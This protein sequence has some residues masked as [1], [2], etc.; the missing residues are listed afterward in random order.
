MN[1]KNYNVMSITRI[2]GAFMAYLIGSG[3]ATGQE[4]LQ[5]F[6]SFGFNGLLGCLISLTILIYACNTLLNVGYKHN[7]RKNE[8]VF[9]YFCGKYIGKFLT[10]YTMTFIVAVYAIMLSGTGATLQQYYGVPG[11]VGAILMAV[12]SGG[13]L[14][15]GLR[16]IVNIIAMIGPVIVLFTVVIS[17]LT[18]VENPTAIVNGAEKSVELDMLKA[19]PNWV[20]SA[21][22]YAGL[23]IPGLASFL[24][25]IGANSKRSKDI[26]YSSLFGPILFIGSLFLLALALMTQIELVNGTQIPVM[27]LANSVLPIYASIFAIIIFFGIFTTATPLLWTVCSRFAEDKTPKYNALVVGLVLLGLLGGTLLPFAQLVNWIY[28]SVGY[29]GLLFLVCA[30]FKD[31]RVYKANK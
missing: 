11:Y 28:P 26:K 20:L 23:M 31:I 15:L 6:V 14:L 2:S 29:A 7:I 27:A 21:L 16:K 25:A 30:I 9:V 12:L 22:L 8:D 18:I 1:E 3:F 13:T 17:I 4:G 5:F 10:W 19:S 24:P